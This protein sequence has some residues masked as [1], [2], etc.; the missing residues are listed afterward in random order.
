MA[1]GGKDIGEKT[2]GN[3]SWIDGGEKTGKQEWGE[4]VGKRQCGEKFG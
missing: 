1:G 2:A 3:S 4:A